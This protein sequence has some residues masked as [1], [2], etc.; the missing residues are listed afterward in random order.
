MAVM[1]VIL[2][3]VTS[4]RESASNEAQFNTLDPGRH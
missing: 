1:R 4:F 3:Q 2:I